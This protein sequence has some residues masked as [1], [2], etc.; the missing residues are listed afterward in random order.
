MIE[1]CRICLQS[2]E[3]MTS[4]IQDYLGIV[5]RISQIDVREFSK[6]YF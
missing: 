3:K 5:K 1:T 2:N 4:D 6:I